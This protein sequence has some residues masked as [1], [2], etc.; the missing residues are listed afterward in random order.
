MTKGGAVLLL[1]LLV[2]FGG[3]GGVE[4][5]VD[6]IQLV[7]SFAVSLLGCCMMFVGLVML[8]VEG[9]A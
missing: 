8:R 4:Q 1:G 6:N 3:T 9:N 5:S 2:A 7:A